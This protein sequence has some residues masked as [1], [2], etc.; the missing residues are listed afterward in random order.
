[1]KK[2]SIVLIEDFSKDP[3]EAATPY[4]PGD[5]IAGHLTFNTSS[6]IR[7]TC[8]KIRFV[9]L[10]STKVAK[11]AEEVYVL[12]QQVVLLG[13][14]NNA[15]DHVLPEGKHS[16]PFEFKVPLHHIP[17]SGKYRHGSVKYMLTAFITQKT[18]LGGMQEIKSNLTIQ[19]KD[20]VNC[21][22]DPYCNPASAQGSSNVKPDT[23][24]PKNLAKANVQLAQSSC[25][26]GQALQIAIDLAHPK[27]I[28][29]DPGCWIKLIRTEHY[30][31]GEHTKD[32]S[33]VVATTAKALS[34]DPGSGTGRIVAELKIP[35]DALP[36]MV[37][38]K[39]ISVQYHLLVLFDMRLRVGFMDRKLRRSLSKKQWDKLLS[40]PGGFEV[41]VPVVVG[42]ISDKLHQHRPS[43]FSAAELQVMSGTDANCPITSLVAAASQI[44]LATVPRNGTISAPSDSSPGAESPSSSSGT[45]RLIE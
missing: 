40:L 39:I 15:S 10:V 1:M 6:S 16:W 12:N 22:V 3:K 41:K 30:Y 37:T 42:T 43:P 21:A 34:V 23:N 9:G 19:L 33:H 24:K 18:F 17:S 5:A 20:L 31:A 36:T 38:T 26:Q 2:L 29:R 8:V 45:P 32:Y 28:Q 7:Y 14:P 27:K 4:L 13:N 25:V 44:S 11:T 35:S